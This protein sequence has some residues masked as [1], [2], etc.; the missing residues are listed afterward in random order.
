VAT[1]GD[2]LI[3]KSTYELVKDYF[4]TQE[5]AP[6]LLKGKA[7]ALQVYKVLGEKQGRRR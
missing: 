4:E 5:L 1:A 6:A 2:I 3:S 7:Q